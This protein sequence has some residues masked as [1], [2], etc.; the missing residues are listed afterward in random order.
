[1]QQDV[2][3]AVVGGGLSG[4]NAAR[5]L[6]QAGRSVVVLEANDYAGGRCHNAHLKGAVLELGGQW[7]ASTQT[8]VLALIREF[9]LKI[10]STYQKGLSTF[11]YNGKATRFAP[12]AGQPISL[13]AAAEV[14]SAVAQ[15]DLVAAQVP[16]DAP[17]NAPHAVEWDSQTAAT[18]LEANVKSTEARDAMD[19]TLGGR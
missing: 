3:V 9:G 13:E 10:Y 8:H 11:A 18:W 19:V 17:Q 15:I 12:A 4:L 1:M 6:V 2:D 7:V 14:A 16:L 5:K